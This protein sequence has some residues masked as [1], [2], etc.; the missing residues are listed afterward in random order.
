MKN[1]VYLHKIDIEIYSSII[2]KKLILTSC[3]I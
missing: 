3:S 2:V 1:K